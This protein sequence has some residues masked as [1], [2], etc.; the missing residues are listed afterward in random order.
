MFMQFQPQIFMGVIIH[1]CHTF[2]GSLT[3]ALKSN[4]SGHFILRGNNDLYITQ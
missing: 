4:L 2:N 3:K 1:I